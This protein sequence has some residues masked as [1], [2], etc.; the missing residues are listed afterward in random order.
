M[1]KPLLKGW[2]EDKHTAEELKTYVKMGNSLGV[3]LEPGQVVLDFDPRRYELGIDTRDMVRELGIDLESAPCVSTG[4]GGQHYY[5]QVEPGLKFIGNAEKRFDLP[6][7][8]IKQAGNLVVAP[9]SKNEKGGEYTLDEWFD[10]PTLNLP[11][12]F[13]RGKAKKENASTGEKGPVWLAK[14]LANLDPTYYR[15]YDGWVKLLTACHSATGGCSESRDVF[16]SWCIR[17]T[18]YEGDEEQIGY[19]W[20]QADAEREGGATIATLA[21]VAKDAGVEMP[22]DVAAEDFADLVIAP[23]PGSEPGPLDGVWAEVSS[24]LDC[25][26]NGNPRD[27]LHNARRMAKVWQKHIGWCHN[28]FADEQIATNKTPFTERNNQLWSDDR[29]VVMRGQLNDTVPGFEP[30]ITRMHEVIDEQIYLHRY[31]P[32]IDHLKSLEWDGKD[33][34]D[35]WIVDYMDGANDQYTREVGRLILDAMIARVERPGCKFDYMVVFEGEQGVGKSTACKILGGQWFSDNA[36]IGLPAKDAVPQM[37]GVW[38]FEVGELDSLRKTDVREMKS[39]LSRASDR[40]RQAYARKALT[41][42]RQCIFIGTTN[43]DTYLSDE[44]GNRRF[45][46]VKVGQVDMTGLAE[47]RNQLMAEVWHKRTNRALMLSSASDMEAVKAQ[48]ERRVISGAEEMI[49]QH[50]A[51]LTD[52]KIS[53]TSLI[54]IVGGRMV[55]P[56]IAR[57]ISTIMHSLGW[58]KARWRDNVEGMTMH[59]RGYRLAN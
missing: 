58:E 52:K 10:P 23:E 13:H 56:N 29:V 42:P 5:F 17:D 40:A 25:D 32:V 18:D 48:E 44:T 51:L 4:G 6:G 22:S 26:K 47:I 20:D 16:V 39:F 41:V 43:E 55:D 21:K 7:F 12:K 46:P 8:E 31:H 35:S 38:V 19:K 59:I 15:E 27:S 24:S 28:V 2:R 14:Y 3:A 50:L 9:G 54:S 45:L 11:E 37:M 33:R 49:T 30:S 53:S 1:K 57:R 36:P 34:A